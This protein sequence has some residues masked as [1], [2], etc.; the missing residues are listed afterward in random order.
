MP[1]LPDARLAPRLEKVAFQRV[2]L[3]SVNLERMLC[4]L[5][6]QL[7]ELYLDRTSLADRKSVV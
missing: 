5:G 2:A 7:R 6:G 4:P 3:E 1:A